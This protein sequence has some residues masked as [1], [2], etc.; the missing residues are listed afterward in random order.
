MG[1]S[2]GMTAVQD[3]AVQKASLREALSA[4]RKAL[5]PQVLD[6][7]GLK[8]QA[9]FLASP[10][11]HSAKTIALYAPIRGE[12][13]TRDILVAALA[14]GKV[15]C[16]PLSQVHGRIMSFRAITSEAELERVLKRADE[17]MYGVKRAGKGRCEIRLGAA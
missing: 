2:E 12:V 10:Y 15:V 14:D 4:K 7:R 17:L 11:Y 9:R 6:T 13:P 1:V 16:Y 3:L 8:V 5:T